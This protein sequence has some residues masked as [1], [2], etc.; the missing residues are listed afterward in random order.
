MTGTVYIVHAID[1]EGPLY[2]SIEAKF[3]RLS[4]LFGIEE[5]T[6]NRNNLGRLERGEIDLGEK[7]ELIQRVL[8]SH[9]ANTLGS[10]VQISEM[11][12]RVCSKEFRQRLPDVDGNGW[13]YNWFCMDHVGYTVNPRKRD[14]GH[15]NIHDSYMALV[16]SQPWSM[17][18]VEFH[19]HPVSTYREAHRCATHYLRTDDLYQILCRRII[20]RGFFPA[21]YRA[22][23]QAERP[24][25]HWFLE[26]FI[27][28]DISNMATED[29]SDID[30]SI[31]F[32]NGRSGNWRKAPS[33]WSVYHPS[34]DDYQLE[35][36]CRRLI[37]RA[38]NLR[39]R[40]ACMSQTEMDK[41]FA[42]ADAGKDTLVGVCSHD[43]RDLQS[44]VEA[45]YEMLRS[46]KQR[47][48]DVPFKY[49]RAAE[50][51]R[52]QLDMQ[53]REQ[54]PLKLSL[55]FHQEKPGEDVPYIEVR[56][57]Q[58][59]VFGP[60]PFLAIKTKSQRYI[61]DNM[62]FSVEDGVWYYAFQPDTLPLSDV[63]CIG[64]AA[65]DMLGNTEVLHFHN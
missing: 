7:T 15:H 50:A 3:E 19:F 33:D 10:W 9:R 20:D 62:D 58:G 11:L 39:S 18:T 53:E 60:Q 31:D 22:G 6:P 16:E 35:G 8:R 36:N 13:V 2:E 47:F 54:L 37:G 14:M 38:L 55:K 45:V 26:Q 59:E 61:H 48:P 65:N 34:H 30:S 27:P 44:E 23:F 56:T 5:I 63:E 57:E 29:T 64:V 40:I 4:E 28:F 24:D 25:S 46:S 1:T 41:A 32:K 43:W 51:F 21:C 17:D 52:Q 12:D 49:S 42:R